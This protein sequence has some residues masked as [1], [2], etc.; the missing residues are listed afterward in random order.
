MQQSKDLQDK[1]IPSK[2]Y[3]DEATEMAEIPTSLVS[4]NLEQSI[5]KA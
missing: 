3:S 4:L 5:L 1:T 2:D